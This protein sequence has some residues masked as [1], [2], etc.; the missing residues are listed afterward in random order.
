MA[1]PYI[2]Y[3]IKKFLEELKT[4]AYYFRITFLE[5]ERLAKAIQDKHDEI[6]HAY[7]YEHGDD[8]EVWSRAHEEVL[9]SDEVW[10]TEHELFIVGG[11]CIIIFHAFERFLEYL[12][13]FVLKRDL[14]EMLKKQITDKQKEAIRKVLKDDK[15]DTFSCF[16]DIFP[17]VKVANG[18]MKVSELNAV[19]NVFKH[20]KGPA[21]ERLKIIRPDITKHLDDMF[22][23]TL[24]PFRGHG[25]SIEQKLVNEYVDAIKEFLFDVFGVSS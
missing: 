14:P 2:E 22:S 12:F 7:D 15:L 9:G 1:E 5:Q 25:L 19:C 11:Y 13:D 3:D 10:I 23:S 18:Y 24:R 16:C 17:E 8:G 4:Y 6:G 20:G 21:L